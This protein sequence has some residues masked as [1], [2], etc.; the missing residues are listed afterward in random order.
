M[1]WPGPE[2]LLPEGANIK[3]TRVTSVYWYVSVLI[4]HIPHCQN[5]VFIVC[6]GGWGVGLGGEY[7][8]VYL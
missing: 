1:P 5:V 7:V 2:C 6:V 8:F 4:C 3:C